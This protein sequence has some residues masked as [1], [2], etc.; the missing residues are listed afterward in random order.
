[1]QICTERR[2]RAA[3]HGRRPVHP[4]PGR[5][6]CAC[7]QGRTSMGVRGIALDEGD[8]VISLSILRH[9]DATP[10]ERA[11]YLKQSGAMRRAADRRGG[12][13]GG[14][15]RRKRRRR[16]TTDVS[17][18]AGALCRDGRRRAVRADRFREG[19]GKRTSS[20]E[21]RVTGRGGKGIARRW[22][23]T[24]RNGALVA[25]FP[26]EEGD[27]IMLVTDGGQLIRCPVD[28]IRIAGRATQGV[29]RLRHRRG[30]AA[31]SRS[32]TSARDGERR[33]DGNGG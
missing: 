23:S 5:P 10:A 32:S 1:M 3:D 22:P 16:P 6:T 14:D 26:V 18:L 24:E 30:R 19:Y 33:R 9:F 11:A 27:Q 29:H 17:L 2:R 15:R 25:S 21:Y 8:R 28:G 7:S 31:W 13:A 12:R 20:F 4:L